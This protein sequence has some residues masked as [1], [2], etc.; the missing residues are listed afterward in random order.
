MISR[1]EPWMPN[2]E[3]LSAAQLYTYADA[4]NLFLA[5]DGEACG[6]PEKMVIELLEITTRGRPVS[7]KP[8][9]FQQ[10]FF[11]LVSDGEA[12]ALVDYG[13]RCALLKLAF[14]LFAQEMAKAIQIACSCKTDTQA[15][16]F[17][18][19]TLLSALGDKAGGLQASVPS[20]ERR[21]E[22]LAYATERFGVRAFDEAALPNRPAE[23]IQAAMDKSGLLIGLSREYR[24]QMTVFLERY[25]EILH[26][27]DNFAHKRQQEINRIL[28]RART[29]R[30]AVR[31]LSNRINERLLGVIQTAWRL[32]LRGLDARTVETGRYFSV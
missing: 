26:H 14:M 2:G 4:G 18:H 28:G 21:I 5:P 30:V 32:R 27:A 13:V 17:V 19:E 25:L 7:V 22:I 11:S 24:R 8:R 16:G 1:C 15:D 6:G 31:K 12:E 23:A 3:V 20:L 10:E 29:A 9:H